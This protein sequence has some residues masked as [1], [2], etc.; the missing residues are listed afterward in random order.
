MIRPY[1]DASA[2]ERAGV[3]GPALPAWSCWVQLMWLFGPV[4]RADL[5]GTDVG[6]Q[7]SE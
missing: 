5:D 3:C 7:F 6:L 4:G 1:C 2:S